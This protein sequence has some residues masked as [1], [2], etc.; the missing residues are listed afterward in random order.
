MR[1][2]ITQR[3]IED[4]GFHIVAAEADWPD[5]A[6]IDSRARH[7]NVPPSEWTAF[8]RL[9]TWMWRNKETRSFVDWLHI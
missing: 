7:S 8:T 1:A 5:A 3:L 4:N 9:P 6:R 2:R